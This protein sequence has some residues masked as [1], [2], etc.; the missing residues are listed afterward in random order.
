MAEERQRA[1]EIGDLVNELHDE[2]GMRVSHL[3]ATIGVSRQR[4]GEYRRTALAFPPSQRRRSRDFHYYTIAARAARKLGIKPA[5]ALAQIIKNK[6]QTTRQATA[7]LAAQARAVD[8]SRLA[9]KAGLL[10]ARGRGLVGRCHRTDFRKVMPRLEDGSAKLVI[11]DPPYGQYAGLRDAHPSTPAASQRTCDG[12]ADAEARELTVDLLRLMRLKL[13]PGGCLILFRPGA[14]TDPAWLS[15]AIEEQGYRCHH[16]VTWCKGRAKLGRG[17]EPYGITSERLLVLARP[18][19]R[20]LNHDNSPRRDV[21]DFPPV[22]AS[23]AT[24]DDHHVF[25]KPVALLRLLVGKHTDEGELVVEPF[26]GTGPACR[27]AVE[28]NRAWLYC[29]SHP[30]SFA[31]GSTKLAEL[32]KATTAKAG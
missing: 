20:L 14:G 21:V 6:I 9:S 25:E 30:G 3:A 32:L 29:D 23:Y 7:Y 15:R 8:K 4:L 12:L 26:G 27:A 2:H 11:A 5:D 10:L 28:M 31:L 16:V 13:A 22:R 18:D 24:S 1:F 17:D 19:E